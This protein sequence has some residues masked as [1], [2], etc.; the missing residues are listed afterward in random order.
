MAFVFLPPIRSV[1][2]PKE[3]KILLSQCLNSTLKYTPIR[4]QRIWHYNVVILTVKLFRLALYTALKQFYKIK[5]DLEQK[6][7]RIGKVCT[8]MPLIPYSVEV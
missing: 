7:H 5:L 4:R 8:R 6:R 3:S 1:I 2:S